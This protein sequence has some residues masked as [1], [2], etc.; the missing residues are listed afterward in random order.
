MELRGFFIS[1]ANSAANCPRVARVLVCRS[2]SEYLF[3][4]LI[5]LKVETMYS[6]S[7]PF[8]FM[9]ETVTSTHRLPPS[10]LFMRSSLETSWLSASGGLVVVV[11]PP[12]MTISPGQ[13]LSMRHFPEDVWHPNTSGHSFPPISCHLH[14]VISSKAGFKRTIR[15]VLSWTISP[16]PAFCN[17]A[18]NSCRVWP[19]HLLSQG[20]DMVLLKKLYPTSL[21]IC[22]K[23][24]PG[25]DPPYTTRVQGKGAGQ[26]PVPDWYR[27]GSPQQ[28]IHRMKKPEAKTFDP[29]TLSKI[30][31]LSLRAR[32]VVEG[33]L[34]GIHKSPHKGSSIEFLEHKE[35]SPGDEIKHIDW[36]V[37]GRS[38]KYYLKQFEDETNLRAYLLLDTSGSMG[39]GSGAMTKLE[40]ATTLAACL[41]YLLLTQSDAVGLL[42]F[43]EGVPASGGYIPPRA[44]SNHLQV[45]LVPFMDSRPRGSPG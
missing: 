35:Y 27:G 20:F 15:R 11:P 3:F 37:L 6:T 24:S 32:Y 41:C 10:P 31:D 2:S 30:S 17:T 28:T 36:K 29:A 26:S 22:N 40:Y 42:L 9:G 16:T 8:P 13:W 14:T 7:P 33:T 12:P 1:W 39:Y 21:K 25:G 45:L 19:C 34:A 43:G 23:K 44:K 38:D 18:C 4:S 5:S